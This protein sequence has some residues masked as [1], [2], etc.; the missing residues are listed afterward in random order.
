MRWML[1]DPTGIPLACSGA[2]LGAVNR[3]EEDLLHVLYI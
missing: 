1:V 3:C 2:A